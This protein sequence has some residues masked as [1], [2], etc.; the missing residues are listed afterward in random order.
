[1]A[2]AGYKLFNTGDVLTAAQVNTY[3]MQQ[4]VMVFASSTARDT[5]LSGIL[6]EGLCCYLTD[7]NDFQ[8]Y[9]GSAWVSYGSGDV[10]GITASTPLTGG[11]TSGNI[12]VGI[13]DGTTA[14]KGAVQLTDSTSSTSTTTAATPNSVK[15]AY[16]LAN[17]AIPKTLT[18][19]TGD[20]IYASSANTPARLGIGSTNQVLT[21]SGGVPTWAAAA[22]GGGM[23]L[24]QE[25][26]LSGNNSL[27]FS[28]ISGSY[29][30]LLLVWHGVYFSGNGVFGIR[31]NNDSTSA[32]TT[33]SI[34][35]S[36][37]SGGV[38]SRTAAYI[39]PSV[40]GFGQ[41]VTNTTDYN[42]ARGWLLIDNYASSSKYKEIEG[43]NW[44][45]DAQ[46]SEK[47]MATYVGTYASTTAIT[48][49]D[50]VRLTGSQ[51]MTNAANT[52]VRL[53]GVS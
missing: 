46:Y 40:D 42:L 41:S 28:S 45:Y 6:A 21:V 49:I 52:S 27:S 51:T 35:Y 17:G 15:S 31:L 13:Q 7:V 12:T 34:Y 14:Q 29:K 9:S 48:S 23:T 19:T 4:T 47:K 32:Y 44:F 30:Q 39:Q 50:I 3:L 24:I 38:D 10:T 16:D 2:G 37:T 20:I 53:Y 18:T 22:S 36:N 5:A 26:A 25:T 8:I 1:M 33:N 43:K 11:G